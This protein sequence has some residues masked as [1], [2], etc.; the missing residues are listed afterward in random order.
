MD[1]R[2]F[3]KYSAASF[4]ALL[5]QKEPGY[6]GCVDNGPRCGFPERM[7]LIDAHA[8][9]S[10]FACTPTWCDEASTIDKVTQ[11]GMNMSSFAAV[12]DFKSPSLCQ[13]YSFEETWKHLRDV[14]ALQSAGKIKIV[15]SV[16]DIP[17]FSP[18]GAFVPGALLG[19]EGAAP[20]ISPEIGSAGIPSLDTIFTRINRL[21]R[22]G[23]R[24]V[25]LMHDCANAL[26][27]VMTDILSPEQGGLTEIGRTIVIALMK[28]GI[29]VDV[30]HA[31]VHTLEDIVE[32]AL[33]YRVPIFDSHTALA[34]ARNI[35]SR[36]RSIEEMKWIAQTGGVVCTWP[37]QVCMPN[38]TECPR[39]SLEDWAEENF[40]IAGEIG[41]EHVGLGTDG[42]GIGNN[43]NLVVGY[44]SILD[45]PRL[46]AAM[47]DAGFA[48]WEVAAYMG[49]NF[50]RILRR[51]IG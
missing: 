30:A 5:L 32:I 29:I 25:T 26:G 34:S 50:Y 19:L 39:Y 17:I 18:L 15:G 36:R 45:L 42:G 12:G 24:S 8:H 22:L 1:R 41:F 7:L 49:K 10:I 31:H 20:L 28:R 51:C 23:L 21:Y 43:A 40:R 14:V 33:R 16:A 44:E 2:E 11:I 4:A 9:P 3:L 38:S 47:R 46:A 27:G 37:V 6:A 48:P 35:G 13:S